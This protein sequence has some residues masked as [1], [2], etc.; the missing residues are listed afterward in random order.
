VR[1]KQESGLRVG[2]PKEKKRKK[3]GLLFVISGPSGSGKTTLI[4]KVIQDDL[5]RKRIRKS[6]SFTTRPK[7]SGEKGKRDYFFITEE[8]FKAQRRIKKILEWTKYLGYY[9]GTPKDFVDQ[10]LEKGKNIFLCVDAKGAARLRSLYGKTAVTIFILPPSL[11]ELRKRIE[12]RCKEVKAEE[13]SR[14]VQLAEKEVLL[15]DKFDYC[16]IN[17]NLSKT[18][19][20]LKNIILKRM[21]TN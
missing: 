20:E 12:K 1:K 9:Y 18:V 19:K 3:G 15:A 14:R 7:R 5:L 8:D 17:Q 21:G 11:N 4:E 16:L 13:V 2:L 6:I 10:Q